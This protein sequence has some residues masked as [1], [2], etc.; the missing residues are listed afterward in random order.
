VLG[1]AAQFIGGSSATLFSKDANRKSGHIYYDDGGIDPQ[2]V[3]LYF[4]KYVKLD[5]ATTGHYFA[6]LEQPV[7]TADLVPYE[8]FLESRLYR[9]WARPQG[10]VDFLS[11]VLDKSTTSVALFGVFRHEVRVS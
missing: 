6:E 10:L 8:E 9:E 3:Q 7:A 11:A 5:P 1:K 2:Y 4:D